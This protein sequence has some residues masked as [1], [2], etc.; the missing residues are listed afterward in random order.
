MSLIV[1][2]KFSSDK[3]LSGRRELPLGI[4][5]AS[6]ATYIDANGNRAIAASNVPRFTHSLVGELLGLLVETPRTNLFLNSDAPVT[7]NVTTEAATYSIWMEGS[8]SVTLSGTAS[9]VAKDGSPVI[10]AA[11][12]GTLTLTISGSP[13]LV[14]VEKGVMPTSY[15]PT[16]GATVTRNWDQISATPFSDVMPSSYGTYYCDVDLNGRTISPGVEFFFEANY[17]GA[18]DFT[19]LRIE[20]ASSCLV[21]QEIDN[22]DTRRVGFS[23]DMFDGNRH[24][25]A[26]GINATTDAAYV[27][28]V[29]VFENTGEAHAEISATPTTDTLILGGRVGGTLVL[30]GIIKEFAYYDELLS[31]SDLELLTANGVPEGGD[32]YIAITRRTAAQMRPKQ[33][34]Q[35]TPKRLRDL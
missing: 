22:T 27:D 34:M 21:E 16:E 8:G 24:R 4:S 9:G 23:V 35:K 29:Q 5:R 19:V 25:I 15:I 20:N 3:S 17:V 30:S 2:H 10:V 18:N 1:H 26:F 13:D 31:Q 32:F 7:Q 6:N 14:Q 12:A 11:T 33:R 28:G